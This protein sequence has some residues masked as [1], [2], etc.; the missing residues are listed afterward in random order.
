MASILVESSRNFEEMKIAFCVKTTRWILLHFITGWFERHIHIYHKFNFL[1]YLHRIFYTSKIRLS[2]MSQSIWY[3]FKKFQSW[4]EWMYNWNQPL[5]TLY[6]DLVQSLI[7]MAEKD[8]VP[9]CGRIRHGHKFVIFYGY[10]KFKQCNL[11]FLVILRI[12][13]KN[14]SFNIETLVLHVTIFIT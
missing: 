7:E 10:V 2:V 6:T 12:T 1:L 14:I 11:Y 4:I 3:A 13:R 5:A 8:L 9:H